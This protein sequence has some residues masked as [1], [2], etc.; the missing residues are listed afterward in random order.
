MERKRTDFLKEPL[1]GGRLKPVPAVLV[2][3]ASIFVNAWFQVTSFSALVSWF[4]E[5]SGTPDTQR[6]LAEIL[7][8]TD[9]AIG[10]RIAFGLL[11]TV[12]AMVF[13]LLAAYWEEKE[14]NLLHLLERAGAAM[15][16]PVLLM[17]AGALLMNVSLAAGVF[18]GIAAAVDCV[19][20]I[21]SAGKKVHVNG[22]LLIG[23][24]TVF[25]LLTAAM[26][27]R[28][29]IATMLGAISF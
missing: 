15:L 8:Q 7:S 20:V 5:T 17:L 28:N 13:L 11:M 25:F 27:T 6:L 29:H 3:I 10:V 26:L 21:V 22:Y 24:A 19:A 12:F 14:K 23:A 1:S 2:I 9:T 18:F 16:V 4:L